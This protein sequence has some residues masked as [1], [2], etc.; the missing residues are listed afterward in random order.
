MKMSDGNRLSFLRLFSL[1]GLLLIIG[2]TVLLILAGLFKF[3]VWPDIF[4]I[5]KQTFV[6]LL[7]SG[8]CVIVMGSVLLSRIRDVFKIFLAFMVT[9]ALGISHQYV[10]RPFVLP[11]PLILSS[12]SQLFMSKFLE[13]IIEN[14]VWF[15]IIIGFSGGLA[16][17]LRLKQT[18][19]KGTPET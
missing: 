8:I 10:L 11:E 2:I 5:I 3:I 18:S 17:I 4:L 14:V 6:Y 15:G 12:S 13:D 9:L 19:A 16:L 1:G 7:W